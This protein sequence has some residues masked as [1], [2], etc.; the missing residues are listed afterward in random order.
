MEPKACHTRT[1]LPHRGSARH[2]RARAKSTCDARAMTTPPPGRRARRTAAAVAILLTLVAAACSS[3]DSS[4][5]SSGTSGTS[6]GDAKQ[7][8]EFC[9]Q[10]QNLANE[11][12][13]EGL[14]DPSKLAAFSQAL[15]SL[16]ATAPSAIQPQIQALIDASKYVSQY[17][18]STLPPDQQSN[19][20][21]SADELRSWV[22]GNCGIKLSTT[23]VAL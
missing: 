10:I 8:E 20:R 11:G 17:P 22:D 16:A 21:T 5:G 2:R 18:G 12:L 13:F 9:T 15:V 7:T 4:S 3:S 6:A 19:V 23:T 14:S 1:G